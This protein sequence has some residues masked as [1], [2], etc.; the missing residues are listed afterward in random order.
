MPGPLRM[1]KET[2]IRWMRAID[3]SHVVALR[4]GTSVSVE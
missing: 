3:L 2:R 1:I 4:H